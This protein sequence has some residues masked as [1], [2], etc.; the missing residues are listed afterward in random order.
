MRAQRARSRDKREEFIWFGLVVWLIWF[1]WLISFNH[2]NETNQITVLVRWGLF[3]I[4]QRAELRVML[5]VM[6][7]WIGRPAQPSDIAG[8]YAA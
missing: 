6:S 8:R 5:I 4:L 2:T 1:I 3:S 7:R